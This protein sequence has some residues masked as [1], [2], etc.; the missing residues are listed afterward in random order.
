[1]TH[2]KVLLLADHQGFD[3]DLLLDDTVDDSDAFL[4][5]IELVIAREVETGFMTKMVPKEGSC[6][7]LLELLGNRLFQGAIE[8]A[9]VFCCIS[10]ER[11]S[12]AQGVAL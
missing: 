8:V 6:F 11:D 12:I 1:M 9:K 5:H 10:R 3:N 4:G 7:E 2:R